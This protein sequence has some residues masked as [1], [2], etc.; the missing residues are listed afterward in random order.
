MSIPKG[1]YPLAQRGVVFTNTKSLAITRLARLFLFLQ[2]HI[3]LNYDFYLKTVKFLFSKNPY[4]KTYT[5]HFL[6]F[7]YDVYIFLEYYLLQK[8]ADIGRLSALSYNN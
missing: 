8:S 6:V 2:A 4:K 5:H 7:T 3:L 1:F